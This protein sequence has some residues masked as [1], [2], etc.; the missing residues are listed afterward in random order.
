MCAVLCLSPLVSRLLIDD[1]SHPIF[2]ISVVYQT[3]G[4]GSISMHISREV[5]KPA[6]RSMGRSVSICAFCCT[7]TFDTGIVDRISAIISSYV[8]TR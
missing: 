8:D 1:K 7:E 6:C 5:R 3:G 4:L 2:E